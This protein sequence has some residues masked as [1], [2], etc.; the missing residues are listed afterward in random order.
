MAAAIATSKQTPSLDLRLESLLFSE[1]ALKMLSRVG[2]LARSS[3]NKESH[4]NLSSSFTLLT[5]NADNFGFFW[6]R[7]K[8]SALII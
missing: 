6:Q 4:R 1:A 7:A 3:L 2:A 5:R 8:H